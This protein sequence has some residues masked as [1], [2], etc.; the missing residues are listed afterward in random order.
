MT[1][2][3]KIEIKNKEGLFTGTEKNADKSPVQEVIQDG[4]KVAEIKN[5]EGIFTGTKKNDDDTP[6]KVVVAAT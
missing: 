4:K 1:S 5:D 2:A 6:V 3:P